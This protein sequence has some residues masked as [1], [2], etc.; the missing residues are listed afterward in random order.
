VTGA[1]G[2]D[3]GESLME[4]RRRF[5]EMLLLR[6]RLITYPDPEAM[7]SEILPELSPSDLQPVRPF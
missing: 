6:E 7:A 5:T 3:D 2:D 4:T 1:A